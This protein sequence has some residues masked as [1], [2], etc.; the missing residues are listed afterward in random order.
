MAEKERIAMTSDET[1]RDLSLGSGKG[2][3]FPVV[4]PCQLSKQRCGA[5]SKEKAG[6][7]ESRC[8]GPGWQPAGPTVTTGKICFLLRA[9]YASQEQEPQQL[10][11]L[12]SMELGR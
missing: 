2:H 12:L 5:L 4:A 9:Q 3:T 7:G 11:R 1:G 10:S 8:S 6:P